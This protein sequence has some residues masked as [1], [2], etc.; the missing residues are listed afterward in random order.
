MANGE[1]RVVQKRVASSE[2]RVEVHYSLLATRYSLLAT[3]RRQVRQALR[4]AGQE[5]ADNR[6]VAPFVNLPPEVLPDFRRLH[7]IET[8]LAAG[9][10]PPPLDAVAENRAAPRAVPAR[11]PEAHP[12]TDRTGITGGMAGSESTTRYPFLEAGRHK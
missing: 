6:P 10:L 11:L 2:W 9:H 3:R 1:W 4:R 7:E 5:G 12:R 8:A